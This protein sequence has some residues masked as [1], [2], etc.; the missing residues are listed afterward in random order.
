MSLVCILGFGIAVAGWARD[1]NQ[2]APIANLISFPMMFLSGVFFPV[3]LMPLW[4][5]NVTAFIPLT[6]IVDGLRFI[7]TENKSLLDLGPQFLI[8]G[9]WALIIYFIAARS[10]RWE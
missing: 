4:L 8:I 10:F 9:L 5:Q 3:Y 1:Q 6:A 2:S 7:T